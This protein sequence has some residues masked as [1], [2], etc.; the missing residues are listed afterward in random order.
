[1]SGATVGRSSLALSPITLGTWPMGGDGRYGPVDDRQAIDTIYR[2]LDHGLTCF[3]T[4][5]GY[6]SGHAEE[7]LG[8]ALAGRRHEAI[9]ASKFGV[10]SGPPGQPGRDS[11]RGWILRELEGSLRRLRTDYVDIYLVHWP[12]PKTP[13]AETMQTLDDLVRAGKTRLVGVCNFSVEL[14][15][16]CREVRS[17]DVVQVGYNLFDQRM[18]REVFPYCREHGIAVMA[19]GPLAHGLLTGTV[20]A[21]TPFAGRDWRARGVAFGQPIFRADNLPRNVAVVNRLRDEVAAPKGLTVAQL[22]LGWVLR[23]PAVTTAIV[24]A[25]TPREIDE[26]IGASAVRLAEADVTRIEAIMAGALGQ[27]RDFRPFS[28]AMEAWD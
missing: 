28:W 19:Y 17:I 15:A 18:E 4:A 2:A 13:L 23:N 9:I 26:N 3:D 11:S 14:I 1:M 25:R 20:S 27:A 24:G 5:P 7:L 12:D 21:D 22:A 10:V 16:R 6:G 8:S